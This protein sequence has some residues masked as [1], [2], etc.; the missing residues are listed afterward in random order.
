MNSNENKTSLAG[1]TEIREKA[2]V[3]RPLRGP[4]DS[5]RSTFV[6]MRIGNPVFALIVCLCV[7]N[8]AI[9]QQ[10]ALLEP[11][12][13]SAGSTALAAPEPQPG[14]ISG[15][16]VDVNGDIIPGAT[17]VLEGAVPEDH[18]AVLA[19]Y[20][21]FFE[22]N[23]LKPGTPYQVKISANGFVDWTSPAIIPNPGQFIFLTG[24]KLEIAGGMTSVTVYSSSEQIAVEQVRLEEQQRVFGIIP[25]F[26]VVYDPNPAPLTTK[27]KFSLAL[28]A[29][30]DP[31][32]FMGIAILAGSNQASNRLD[33]VQG[34]KGYG[35]RLG[36][37]YT[38]AFT[39]IMLGGAILPSLLHQDPRYYYRGTGS[40]KSRALHALSSPFVCKGD[41]G[42][43]QPNYS[44]VGGDLASGAI[45]NLYYPETNRGS[46][47]LFKNALI[48][49]SGRMV[50]SL[51][52]EF[53]L[54]RFTP[55]TANQN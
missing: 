51:I 7:A 18:R 27:L 29:A 47:L 17:V 33:Y 41:N 10:I 11:Q 21:A 23:E 50:N 55:N 42:R 34:A 26:Y 15:T 53:I 36:A 37:G 16:V 5:V 39:D 43:W 1:K 54:R 12:P 4:L 38:D 8:T 44:S 6:T 31:V 19:N 14:S 2:K 45:S 25:N 52:Q 32:T 35:Q 20:N 9:A 48:T 28:K 22:F 40:K 30:T 24:N 3:D 46:E 13:G 49:S